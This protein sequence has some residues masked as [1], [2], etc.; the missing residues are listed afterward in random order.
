MCNRTASRRSTD[1]LALLVLSAT[2]ASAT[3]ASATAASA[4]AVV[5]QDPSPV[6]PLQT[7]A[8]TVRGGRA[9]RIHAELGEL[10]RSGFGGAVIAAIGG[11]IVLEAGYGFANRELGVPFTSRTTAQIGSLT[12]Q[13][14]A[15]AII[16]LALD[17]RIRFDA[18]VG[19]YLPDAAEPAR[20][21]TIHQLLTHTSGMSE[22]CG[23]DLAPLTRLELQRRCMARPLLFEPGTEYAYS[24]PGYSVLAAV[25]EVVTGRELGEYWRTEI[26]EPNG[27]FDTGF[28]PPADAVVA[29][30]YLDDVD[31]GLASDRLAELEGDYWA[32]KG[33]GAIQATAVDMFGWYE[34]LAGRRAL[35]SAHIEA[36]TEPRERDDNE[37][38]VG[39]GWGIGMTDGEVTRISHAGSDGVFFAYFWWN[40]QNDRFFYIVGNNGEEPVIDAVRLVLGRMSG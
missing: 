3:A 30:G 31:Q 21:V 34:A 32:V 10:T 9:E 4:T 15:M 6:E 13:F 20:A 38:W 29:H 25:V 33:N 19:D 14:T 23:P 36:A 8:V 7:A 18:P 17:G 28:P 37:N 24:N 16:D 11:E 2:A 40:P 27:L 1:L 35:G 12:K 26:F 5:A 39:Y 22:Y